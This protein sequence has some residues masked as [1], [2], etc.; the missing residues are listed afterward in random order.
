[1][2]PEQTFKA[3]AITAT[4]WKNQKNNFETFIV[5]LEKNYKDSTG[6]WKKTSNLNTN[7][8]PK[9]ELM[10]KKAY[11]FIVLKCQESPQIPEHAQEHARRQ[12]LTS[13][14]ES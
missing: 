8:I 12:F 11:E 10:L 1:M 13:E 3:G 9:A 4:I 7:D 6:N 14:A 2:K 5:Q